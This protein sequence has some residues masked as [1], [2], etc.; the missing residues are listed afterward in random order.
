MEGVGEVVEE[1]VGEVREVVGEAG[2]VLEEVTEVDTGAA[3]VVEG[4]GEGDEEDAGD[5]KAAGLER[6]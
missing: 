6:P 1:V 5:L 3:K 2:G 4:V